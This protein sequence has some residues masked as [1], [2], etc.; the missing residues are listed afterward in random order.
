MMFRLKS[1]NLLAFMFLP[2]VFLGAA[3]YSSESNSRWAN[4]QRESTQGV[5]PA[6]TVAQPQTAPNR[7][8]RSSKPLA[9]GEFNKF[10]PAANEGGYTRVASQEKEGFAE[11]KLKKDGKDVAMLAVSDTVTNPEAATKF[12]QSTRQ[13]NGYPAMDQGSTATAVLVDNRFQVKVLSRSPSFTK[14]DRE[15]WLQK[16]D[17]AGI[18]GL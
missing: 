7:L 12:Q 9:G 16:F 13:I 3:C 8:P 11:Y 15:T 10:F 18:A 14:E 2:L 1:P 5:N 17:F 6:A 4:A